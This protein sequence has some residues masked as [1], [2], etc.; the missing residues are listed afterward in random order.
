MGDKMIELK[1]VTKRYK[2]GNL[3]TIALKDL[4]LVIGEGDFV[5]VEGVS[6]TGKSTL[7]NILGCVDQVSEGEYYFKGKLVDYSN[8]KMIQKIR[9][10]NFGFI[11]QNYALMEKYNIYENIEMPLLVRHI[12]KKARKKRINES[13]ELTHFDESVHKYPNELSGGQQQRAAIARVC[14]MNVPVILADEPTGAL[15][16]S[17]AQ[18]ITDLFIDLCNCGKTIILV[19]HSQTVIQSIK[20][21]LE[22]KTHFKHILLEKV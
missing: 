22:D 19:T 9:K 11:F 5:V 6:G 16:E 21:G 12:P 13:I 15:D 3:E 10:D 2:R 8:K 1:N 4:S 20:E 17:N 18:K 7:L 14:A